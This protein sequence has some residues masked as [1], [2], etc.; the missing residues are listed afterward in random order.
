ML[1]PRTETAT[2]PDERDSA[3]IDTGEITFIGTAT[4]LLRV[5]GLTILTDPNFLHAGEHAYLG[6]GLFSKRRTEPALA[7]EQLPALDFVILSHHHGDHFDRRAAQGLNK[8]VPIFT[9]PGGAKKLRK[10]GFVNSRP[11]ETWQSV[12]VHRSGKRRATITAMPGKHSPAVLSPFIPS[13]M[14]SM[15]EIDRP[16]KRPYRIYVTGD[17][18]VHDQLADI[19]KRYA[20]IDLCLIHLGGTKIAGVLLT[21]DAAQGVE[22]LRVVQPRSAIPIH[23]NDYGVFKSPLSEFRAAARDLRDIDMHYLDHGDSHRFSL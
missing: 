1:P 2:D 10:Q 15:I 11:M 5:G 23:Y 7:V 16:D 13:V 12:E 19:P 20:G 9:E 8:M 21:M 17:T 6:S 18:L 14:G 22:A 3:P 4:V